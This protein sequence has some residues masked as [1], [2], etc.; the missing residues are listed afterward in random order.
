MV[1]G[2]DGTL[3]F[4]DP[5]FSVPQGVQ[6]D[7]PYAAV[8]RFRNGT[9]SP[10]ITDMNLPNGIA[11]SP[12]GRILYVNNSRPEMF[13]RA[14]DV[15]RD[16]T[17]SNPRELVRFPAN[18]DLRG[19]PDGMKVDSKGNIWT[20]GPGGITILSPAGVALGR[21]QLPVNSTNIAFGDD[22][23]SVFFTSG[24]TI[25]RIRSLVKGQIPKYFTR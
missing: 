24:S 25:Y 1:F 8:F 17:L 7:L 9:L 22:F 19:V 3:W 11:L 13:V 5:T 20:T 10:V 4:T 14:Y 15:A 2:P 18:P 21:I 6:R 23:Y 12:D 16:G